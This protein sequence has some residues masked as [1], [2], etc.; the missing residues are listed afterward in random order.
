MY[1]PYRELIHIDDNFWLFVK[2]IPGMCCSTACTL[3]AGCEF[4]VSFSWF[5]THVLFDLIG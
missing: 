1:V 3:S 4:T 5:I 2:S